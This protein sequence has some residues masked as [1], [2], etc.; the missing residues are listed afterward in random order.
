MHDGTRK[1]RCTG[2]H[3]QVARAANCTSPLA[4]ESSREAHEPETKTS[5]LRRRGGGRTRRAKMTPSARRLMSKIQG[6]LRFWI[7]AQKLMTFALLQ[8]R[9][10]N[11]NFHVQK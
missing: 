7:S 3:G 8:L 1:P 11:R 6:V 9:L 5:L 4:Q 10:E 2:G